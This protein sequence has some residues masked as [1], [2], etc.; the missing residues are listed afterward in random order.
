MHTLVSTWDSL[1]GKVCREATLAGKVSEI[2]PAINLQKTLHLGRFFDTPSSISLLPVSASHCKPPPPPPPPCSASAC[3][4][5]GKMT[6]TWGSSLLGLVP[7]ELKIGKAI[8]SLLESANLWQSASSFGLEQNWTWF[9][10]CRD[11]S[12]LLSSGLGR[13][14]HALHLL[15]MEPVIKRLVISLVLEKAFWSA[16]MNNQ[17]VKKFQ[18]L[19]LSDKTESPQICEEVDWG[20]NDL[21]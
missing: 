14:W 15:Q 16:I 5:P 4:S 11:P 19:L 17:L 9:F 18:E 6:A 12:I 2:V 21:Q 1:S 3:A 8:H 10:G 7:S 13:V 20:T